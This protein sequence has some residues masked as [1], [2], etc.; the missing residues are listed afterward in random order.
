MEEWKLSPLYQMI[1]NATRDFEKGV[2]LHLDSYTLGTVKAIMRT[3]KKQDKIINAV[4]GLPDDIA[5]WLKHDFEALQSERNY[6]RRIGRCFM[7]ET[8]AV[9]DFYEGGSGHVVR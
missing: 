2:P 3:T 5:E 9:R 4:P 8:Q 1:Q 6:L 7:A